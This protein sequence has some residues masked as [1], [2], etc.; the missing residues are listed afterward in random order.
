MHTMHAGAL[1]SSF[2]NDISA[3]TLYKVDM[4]GWGSYNCQ[5]YYVYIYN[6]YFVAT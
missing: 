2:E 1:L 5:C 3:F 4:E 6:E